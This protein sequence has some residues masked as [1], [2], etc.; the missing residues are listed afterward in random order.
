MRALLLVL[1]AA[2]AAQVRAA[3]DDAAALSLAD[4]APTTTQAAR[5]W[6]V[7]AEAVWSESALRGGTGAEH[8]EHLF[9]DV[10]YDKTFAPAWRVVFADLLDSHWRERFSH[11]SA[12][13]TVI[14]AYVS[15]QWRPDQ[16]ADLGRINTRYGVALGYNPTDYFRA[17]AIRSIISIDPASLREN[18]LGSVMIRG[19]TLW[20]AGSFTALY[21][22]KLADRPNESAFS[23]D[24]G[25][26]NVRDRWLLA[27]SHEISKNLNP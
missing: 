24:F 21:S 19:Q 26:T 7:F 3:D 6:R 20:T 23:P 22:P 14:D 2:A 18:R 15:W 8:D 16:I 1:L 10:H 25:A 17:N 27:G 11:Q 5:D 13:N 9:L 12:V 4:K